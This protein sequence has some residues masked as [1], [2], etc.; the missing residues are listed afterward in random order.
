MSCWVFSVVRNEA[1]LMPYFVRHYSTFCD[2][3]IL[4]DDASDDGT[5]D[6]AIAA[7]AEVRPCPWSGLDDM[8]AS[9][10][11]SSQYKEAFQRAEWV[12]WVDADE[13]LYHPHITEHL[14]MLRKG[15]VT[16]P[17][18]EGY[19]MFSPQTPTTEGQIYGE[20]YRG[21]PDERYTKPVIIDPSIEM[22]WGPGRHEFAASAVTNANGDA[23]KLLHYRWFGESDYLSRNAKNMSRISDTNLA[24]GLGIEVTNPLYEG[25]HSLLWYRTQSLLAKPCV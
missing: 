10:L 11:A 4:Y 23:I 22:T 18:V 19:T 15:G 21:V 20:I 12:A 6:I 3:I 8:A 1:L 24:F 14:A 25:H 16:L 5:P 2:R 9:A 13:F 7:G 17:R